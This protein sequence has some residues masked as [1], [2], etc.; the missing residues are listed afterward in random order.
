MY[1]PLNPPSKAHTFSATQTQGFAHE[2]QGHG[3]AV[4][5]GVT[6]TK[7]GP[8]ITQSHISAEGTRFEL[9]VPI[10]QYVGLANRWFQPLTHLSSLNHIQLHQMVVF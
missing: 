10:A 1:I 7:N 9:V 5:S 2:P 4:I 8:E 3:S 6:F